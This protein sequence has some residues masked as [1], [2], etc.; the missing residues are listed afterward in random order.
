M[1]TMT[2]R[3]DAQ[4]L[5][6]RNCF[7][8]LLFLTPSLLCAA[9]FRAGAAV[10]DITPTNWPVYLVG[11]FSERAAEKAWDPFDRPCAGVGRR[12]GRDWRS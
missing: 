5:Q 9:E 8:F 11:S 2:V 4:R 6:L 12:R 10:G 1:K 7:L 3:F